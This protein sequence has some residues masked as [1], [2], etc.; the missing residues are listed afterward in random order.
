MRE[1][2]LPWKEPFYQ[3]QKANEKDW[4][5]PYSE[6]LKVSEKVEELEE[7]LSDRAG[8]PPR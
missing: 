3:G 7:N 1:K 5:M 8:L 4:E 6:N 2:N